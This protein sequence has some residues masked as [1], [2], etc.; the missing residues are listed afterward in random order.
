M[1]KPDAAQRL[2][3]APLVY[4]RRGFPICVMM[5]R[6]DGTIADGP[7]HAAA[8]WSW[9]GESLVLQDA[10]GAATARLDPQDGAYVGRI[11][12][13]I[14]VA[15]HPFEWPLGYR[16]GGVLAKWLQAIRRTRPMRYLLGMPFVNRRDFLERAIASVPVCSIALSSSTIRP[17]GSCAGAI[18]LGTS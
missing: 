11:F 5:L 7:G 2:I 1:M 9:D 6:A 16:F 17:S 10:H 4:L 13:R 15:L 8:R 14:E 3:G 18:R 12:D